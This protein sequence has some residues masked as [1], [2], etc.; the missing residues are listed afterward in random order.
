MDILKKMLPIIGSIILF[1]CNSFS[2]TSALQ[3]NLTFPFI[4]N[5]KISRKKDMDKQ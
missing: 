3:I 5:I 4:V 2:E 1:V